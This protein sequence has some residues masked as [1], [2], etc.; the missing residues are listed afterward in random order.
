ML[1]IIECISFKKFYIKVISFLIQ[2]IQKR[3]NDALKKTPI[4]AFFFLHSFDRI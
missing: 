1:N 4:E 3:F 2:S